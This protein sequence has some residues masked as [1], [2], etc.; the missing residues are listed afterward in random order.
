MP[1]KDSHDTSAISARLS[2][3]RDWAL[4][5]WMGR[6]SWEAMR[7]LANRAPE[8]GGLGYDLSIQA[9][10]GLVNGAK[11]ARG[12]MTMARED[13]RE[14]QSYEVDERARAARNDLVA[15]YRQRAK[16]DA[17]IESF[18]ET[19]YSEDDANALARLVDQRARVAR[20]LELADKRLDI[21]Q[22]REAKLHGL[23]APTDI[24]VD[25]THHDAIAE[26]LNAMLERAGLPTPEGKKR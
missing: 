3:E 4:N 17:A 26:E 7:S 21:A 8:E 11:E 24:K 16:L 22:D 10:K 13:R 20:E 19:I 12:D 23:N 2:H 9:L 5:A 14:R 18:S 1:P 15:L 6:L 25:V